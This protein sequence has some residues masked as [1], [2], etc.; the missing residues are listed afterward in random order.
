MKK[1][2]LL[3]LTSILINTLAAQLRLDVA[4]DVKIRGKM[5]INT[6]NSSLIIGMDSGLNTTGV[7]NTFIGI[8]AGKNT[9]TNI[10]N[11]FVGASAGINNKG[12]E[13]TFLGSSAGAINIVGD[14][15]VFI[16]ASASS[17]TNDLNKSIAIGYKAEVACSNCAV[18]GGTGVDA[19]KV[20][21]STT[22]PKAKLHIEGGVD[23][24]LTNNGY[25]VN[26]SIDGQNLVI[27][28]NEIIARNNGGAAHLY[29]NID[30]G[31]VSIGGGTVPSAKLDVN[32]TVR[33]R[34][35]PTGTGDL[36]RVDA[37]G[38]L[39]RSS[40][41]AR[42]TIDPNTESLLSEQHTLIKEK[43]K[44]LADLNIE[45]E[46][47]NEIIESLQTQVTELKSLVEKL[48]SDKTTT[49]KSTSYVLPLEQ[50]SFLAQNQ[51]NP[52]LE[53]T[54]VDYFVPVDVKNAYIQVTS[55]DGKILGQVKITEM[56]KGQLTIQSKN[57]PAGTYFYSLVLD[58]QIVESKR[59]VLAR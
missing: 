3:F 50:Q 57:Y 40:T 46:Q 2:G 52:F 42:V 36:V 16:G 26:G 5:D 21:I 18:I 44:A 34:N 4:G 7:S 33:I 41:A 39:Y 58:G 31:N 51:P 15:N 25:L 24:S 27:D 6:A 20:G 53:N 19:V 59:M 9:V 14:K 11:T 30:S 22:D 54:I 23:A 8:S 17:L 47:Q 32:G 38:N 45:N 43:S 56:G 12:N 29:L 28:N 55:L 13:N 48:L 37:S 35:I 49:P 1:I 10:R